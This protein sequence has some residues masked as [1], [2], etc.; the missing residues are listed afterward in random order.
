VVI[1]NGNNYNNIALGKTATADSEQS[2]NGAPKGNDGSTLT[3]WCANDGNLNH[4]WRVDLGSSYNLKGSEVTWE[5]DGKV[6]KYK[7]EVSA[8]G[9]D[10]TLKIDKTS[11]TLKEQTQTDYFTADNVRY[12][13]ITVTGLE[14]L[15]W[16][17]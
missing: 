11:N 10:W 1:F 15:A 14:W 12:V 8:N 2:G 3:R 9:T 7:I 6:Y 5:N 4:W 13:K 16:G 17:L